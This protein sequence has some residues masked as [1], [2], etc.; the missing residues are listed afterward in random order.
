MGT[1]TAALI[2]GDIIA[3]KHASAAEVATQ[4]DDDLCTLHAH[5]SPAKVAV[6]EEIA[7][8]IDTINA[9]LCVVAVSDKT[10]FR[11]KLYPE[12]KAKRTARKPMLLP[13]LREHLLSNYDAYYR[14]GLEADDILGILATHS[15]LVR[16][17]IRVIVSIDKDFRCVP[18]FLYNW[19][20]PEQGIVSVSREDADRR[21]LE[22]TLT[23]DSTDNYPGLPGVGA[24][25]AERLL[26]Q[27]FATDDPWA[28]IVSQF[29]KAGLTS[30][31]ALLQARL[32]RI[33]R[34]DEYDF[35]KK[36]PILWT[37]DKLTKKKNK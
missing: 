28:F 18:G 22:Q 16:A 26:E 30:A 10:N 14:P 32:A 17:D 5:L 33:L 35:K 24:V 3:Y 7:S 6:D 20:K 31:D 23:G 2:D 8:L 11:H 37:A 34:A 29:E 4:W 19:N 12:Y 27:A 1:K 13:A 25:K 21:H 9:D 15:T 36:Q